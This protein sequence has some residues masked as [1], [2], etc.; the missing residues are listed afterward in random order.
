MK[1]KQISVSLLLAACTLMGACFSGTNN[2]SNESSLNSSI[3]DSSSDLLNDSSSTVIDSSDLF[4]DSSIGE[5]ITENENA[6]NYVAGGLH[7]VNV[8]FNNPV[9]EFLANQ[10]TDYE[11]V[12]GSANKSKAAGYIASQVYEATGIKINS[13]DGVDKISTV[14]DSTQY[15]FVGCEELFAKLGGE[16]PTYEKIGVSGYQIE[17]VG[18][19]V[20]I[21]AYTENG[22]QMGVLAFLR[23]VLG[24][25]MFSEDV[26]IYEKDG[27]MMPKMNIIERPDFDYRQQGGALT[28]EEIFGMGFTYTQI[29]IN[30]NNGSFCHNWYEYVSLEESELE[31]DWASNDSNRYQG[32][33]TSRGNKDSYTR[34]I[35]HIT[36]KVKK[37][38][39]ANPYVDNLI[40]AQHDTDVN[41]LVD[42]CKCTSCLASYEYYGS[43]MAGAWISLCNRVALQVNEWLK[44]EEA[45][46][47][48]DKER[49][50]NFLQL[51]YHTTVNAPVGKDEKGN[52]IVD[53]MGRGTP[54][55]EMWFNNDGSMEDWDDAWTDENGESLEAP[56]I[57][58]WTAETD[59]LYTVHNVH[60]VYATSAADWTHSYNDPENAAF[61]TIAKA[62]AGVGFDYY[63]WAYSLSSQGLLYPYNSFDTM[64][65]TTRFFK[66]F[67]AKWI[68][69]QGNYQNPQNSGFEK[70]KRYLESKV[71]FDVNV[72]YN[73]CV[74][75]FFKYYFGEAASKYM[76]QFF[77]EVV[78]QCR[79]NEIENSL[80]GHIHN[81]KILEAENWPEGLM[82]S[83]LALIEKAY[84]ANEL[85]NKNS[86]PEMYEVYRSNIMQEELFPN[87][88][89][90][91]TYA[92]SYSAN[93]LKDMRQ[94]FLK[95][96]YAL[97][98][99]NHAEGRSITE[100][101]GAWD[102]D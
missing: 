37:F 40:L 71:E 5:T 7:D 44:S 19:N 87:Y 2:S 98:N 95:N 52:Y 21:N 23:E 10:K 66:Q 11:I 75:R 18:K 42:N 51:I 83:W 48:F 39:I 62:W 79:Y 12:V 60:S 14:T 61:A 49:T 32:C 70:L 57:A 77:N 13:I 94:K 92:G 81:K 36:E 1:I 86:N 6:T 17:T 22:Y 38:L 59:R 29:F 64:F 28:N 34:L 43:T 25:E 15:I 101:T 74:D 69:W 76:Q 56:V 45:I 4:D 93:V 85:A 8:D 46:S 58:Q 27:R 90:C 73:T 88:V 53:E 30:P 47:I 72:D 65:D 102:L 97:G 31:P 84:D 99:S 63:V 41:H 96:F 24:Y 16:V 35:N 50:F 100:V 82:K 67:G 20:F 78:L 9:S 80:N 89:L 55:E 26:I 33:W 68:M 54:K 3:I 91:T